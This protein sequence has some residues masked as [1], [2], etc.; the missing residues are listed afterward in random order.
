MNDSLVFAFDHSEVLLLFNG[1]FN[2]PFDWLLGLTDFLDFF[3]AKLV[4]LGLRLFLIVKVGGDGVH[5]PFLE[6][7]VHLVLEGVSPVIFVGQELHAM[8]EGV[9]QKVLGNIEAL[10]F[11]H[12]VHL[13]LS[14]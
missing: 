4:V 11:V 13:L 7:D 10:Y 1:E 12:G 3:V 14:S 6:V 9:R 5:Q 2:F 8:F